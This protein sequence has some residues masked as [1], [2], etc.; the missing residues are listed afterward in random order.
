MWRELTS[1]YNTLATEKKSHELILIHP[2]QSHP[3]A[4]ILPTRAHY[5][6]LL[7][8]CLAYCSTLKME[9]TCSSGWLSQNCTVLQLRGQHIS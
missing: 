5:P 7:V 9:A 4:L 3:Q 1:I 8:S 2:S 6:V